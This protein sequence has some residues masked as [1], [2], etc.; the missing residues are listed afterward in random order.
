[1]NPYLQNRYKLTDTEKSLVDAKW[2]GGWRGM[3]WE[4]GVSRCRLL[5]LQW[6]SNEVLLYNTGNHMQS[7]G[8]EHDGRLY[9]KRNVRICMLGSLC[10]TQKLTEHV[11]YTLI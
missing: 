1:M 6:I 7:L 3:D 5:H 10:C 8:I 9:E 11:K 4:F 2:E